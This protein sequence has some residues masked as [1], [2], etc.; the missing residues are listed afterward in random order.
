VR[1]TA[2]LVA[3]G[4]LAAGCGG[5]DER[6]SR[7]DEAPTRLTVQETAGVPAAFV[8]FGIERG[9]F[10][11]RGLEVQLERTQGGAAT[12]PALLDG[13]VDVGGSNVASL[14]LA[15]SKQL[16]VRA[17]AGGTSAGTEDGKDFAVLLAGKDRGISRPRDLEGKTIAVNTLSNVA[18]VAVRA[19]LEQRGVD[20]ESLE[21]TAVPFDEM[22]RAL[23]MGK[24][25]AALVIEPFAT[26][27]VQAGRRV[28]GH[29]YVETDPGMQVGAYAVADRF[30]DAD[31]EAVKAFAEGIKATAEDVAS[32]QDDFRAFLSEHEKIS[33]SLAEAIV[34]PRW[35][36]EVDRRSVERTAALMHRYGL[37]T[38]PID[39]D[40]LLRAG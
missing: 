35:T 24:V 4:L 11:E 39:T 1:V 5:G 3:L 22:P 32:H 36:G 30:A 14:L 20:P 27:S 9:A 17:V 37:V 40:R 23:A 25:D 31:P 19:S 38:R 29:P 8:A 33:P 10:S 18:E 2:V 21:F 15:T 12:I 28:L 6:A 34:L 7:V 13:E 16:P 26:E